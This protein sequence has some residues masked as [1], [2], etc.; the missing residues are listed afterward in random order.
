MLRRVALVRTDVSEERSSPI[1]R[2]ARIGELGTMLATTNNRHT[3]RSNTSEKGS[4]CM[5]YQIED[6]ARSGINVVPSPTILVILMMEALCSTETS[7]LTK[8]TG[9]NIPEDR[10]VQNV[11]LVKFLLILWYKTHGRNCPSLCSLIWHSSHGDEIYPE[12]KHNFTP[13]KNLELSSFEGRK[14]DWWV[15]DHIFGDETFVD[16]RI[17]MVAASVV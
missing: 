7:V 3:L 2:V 13:A 15:S 16:V 14:L 8:A 10:I 6:A 1:I 4:F 12:I 9:H 11:T 5:E 17:C